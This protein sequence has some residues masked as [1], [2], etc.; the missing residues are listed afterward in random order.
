MYFREENIDDGYDALET[1]A[2]SARE[3]MK[4]GMNGW[5][6]LYSYV[7]SGT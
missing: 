7:F 4:V 6:R 1:S 5:L 3:G 2:S